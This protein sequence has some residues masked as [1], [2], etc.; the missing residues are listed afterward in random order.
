MDKS[1]EDLFK[2]AIVTAINYFKDSPSRDSA[3]AVYSIVA[4]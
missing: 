4:V 3:E 2:E 1:I